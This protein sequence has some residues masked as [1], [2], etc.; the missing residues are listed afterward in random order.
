MVRTP[1]SPYLWTVGQIHQLQ[2]EGNR[3]PSSMSFRKEVKGVLLGLYTKLQTGWAMLRGRF[4]NEDGAVATEYVLL[5]VLIALAITVGMGILAVAINQKF[6]D[7]G[8]TLTG[9]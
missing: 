3:F 5:L 7:A 1:S 8:G 4:E 6:D 2:K 9:L